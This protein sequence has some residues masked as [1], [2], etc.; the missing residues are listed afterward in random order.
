MFNV[1]RFSKTFGLSLLS[2][3]MI[4]ATAQA[5]DTGRTLHQWELDN[6]AKPSKPLAS[7]KSS[8]L[9]S[10]H[11]SGMSFAALPNTAKSD[12]VTEAQ[13]FVGSGRQPGM[14]SKW[15]GAFLA[16]VAASTGHKVPAS[17]NVARAWASAGPRVAAS[18]G[19]LMVMKHHVGIVLKVEGPVITLLSGNHNHRV[20]VGDYSASR[21]LAFV[22]LL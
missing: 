19:T 11:Y 17:P 16:K 10:K 15:C 20:A 18:P 5:E 6:T 9:D 13:R 3:S 22:A 21:A 7:S 8:F 1:K 4:F 14:P 2:V 12:L